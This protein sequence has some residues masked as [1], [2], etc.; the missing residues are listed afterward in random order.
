MH[1]VINKLDKV[2]LVFR[3]KASVSAHFEPGSIYIVC[4][5]NITF[6]LFRP[7][8]SFFLTFIWSFFI[9]IFH[10]ILHT[11]TFVTEFVHGP[12]SN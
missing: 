5:A 10:I 11:L 2:R 9:R 4:L 1:S 7:F 3:G 12:I 8:S 6:F